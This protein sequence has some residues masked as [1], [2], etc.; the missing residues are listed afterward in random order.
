MHHRGI[1]IL[2]IL[3]RLEADATI[4]AIFK[5]SLLRKLGKAGRACQ[6]F[7]QVAAVRDWCRMSSAAAA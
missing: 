4:A 1:G 6:M 5:E 3:H 7:S 2:P